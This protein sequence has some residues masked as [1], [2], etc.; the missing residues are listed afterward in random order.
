[1]V[2][3]KLLKYLEEFVSKKR[4]QRFLEV[5][6]QRTNFITVAVEDVYQ[7]HNTSAVVRSCESFGIQQAH[8]IEGRYGKRLDE[9]IAMG[10]QKWVDIHRY[11][12]SLDAI[13]ALRDKG[14]KIVAT[15]PH[16]N[17]SLLN[18]Y[19]L[20]GKIALFFGTENKGLSDDVLTNSDVFLRIPTVGFTQSLNISVSAAILLQYLTTDLR[21]SDL[22]W[23][24]TNEEVLEKR[25]D[26]AKKS[27]KSIDDILFHYHSNI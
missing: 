19:R 4:K 23:K 11:T 15:T 14:Y 9:E 17:G 16:A 10:A 3:M 7:M 21:D 13:N 5:L 20:D 27:I 25:L 26:W 8:L 1:M 22:D 6:D 18:D 12:D 24:L 2:D